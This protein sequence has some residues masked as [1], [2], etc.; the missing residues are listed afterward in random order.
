LIFQV[1]GLRSDL[2]VAT[3]AGVAAESR[4]VALQRTMSAVLGPVALVAVLIVGWFASRQR[5]LRQ[6]LQCAL[7]DANRLRELAEL[8]R[9][10]IQRLTERRVKLIRGV[11]HDVKNPL[12]AAK[13]YAE[14]LKLGIKAPVLPEQRPLLDGIQRTVDGALTMISDLLDLARADSGGLPVNRVDLELW[15]LVRRVAMDHRS[16]AEA[17]GHTLEV[18]LPDRP[19][20]VCTDPA[21]V[22]Q[23]LENLI[24]NAIKYTPAPGRI[25]VTS[26]D[27]GGDDAAERAGWTAIAVSDTG[28]GI[29]TDQREAIFDEFTRL[30]DGGAQK[31]HGLGLAIARRIARL[32]GGDLRVEDSAEGG[33]MFVLSLPIHAQP[34]RDGLHPADAG[35]K[36]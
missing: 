33:A 16:A 19:C 13:G 20:P 18:R 10:E 28:P 30:D 29:S 35:A 31:G 5:R 17:A 34:L 3:R 21:R 36:S 25:T 26:G 23:I 7:S 4:M 27:A 24:S 12:G 9:D 1:I 2:F 22:G 14:L 32:L 8:H 15:A 6:Q 11:T